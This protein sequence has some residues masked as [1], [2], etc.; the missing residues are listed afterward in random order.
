MVCAV[1]C[2]ARSFVDSLNAADASATHRG[3]AIVIP[4]DTTRDIT[5]D[6]ALP[7]ANGRL[8]PR[9]S[10]SAVRSRWSNFH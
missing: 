8:V 2:A 5:R 10:A 7:M 1:V 9:I 4:S 3:N 6:F